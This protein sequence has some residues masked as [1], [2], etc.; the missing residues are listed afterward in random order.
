[1]SLEH[2]S[3]SL[4]RLGNFFSGQALRVFFFLFFFGAKNEALFS[5]FLW[6]RERSKETF[7]LLLSLAQRKKQRDIHLTRALP[8][9][10]GA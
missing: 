3:Y 7:I 2:I 9:M 4:K 10:E 1:M 8:Y 6:R 5:Y